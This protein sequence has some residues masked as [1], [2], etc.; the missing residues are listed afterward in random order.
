MV[1]TCMSCHL[2]I[3][4]GHTQL[5]NTRPGSS[6]Q[7]LGSHVVDCCLHITKLP[8]IAPITF[9]HSQSLHA[10]AWAFLSLPTK[11]RVVEL[12]E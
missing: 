6:C 11:H 5:T 9:P 8:C 12:P 2:C 3:V 10:S 4:M 1:G 7:C